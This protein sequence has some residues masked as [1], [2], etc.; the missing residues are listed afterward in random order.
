MKEIDTQ[1]KNL[2]SNA[3]EALKEKYNDKLSAIM[4]TETD[5]E[6]TL[7]ADE[8]AK[9]EWNEYIEKDHFANY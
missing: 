7:E 3:N 2:Y 8:K 6:I 5:D 1:L 4:K 9:A